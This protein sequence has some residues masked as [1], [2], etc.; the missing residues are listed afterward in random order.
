MNIQTSES[1]S[2]VGIL[3][4]MQKGTVSRVTDQSM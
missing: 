2:N 4:S 3:D 1:P